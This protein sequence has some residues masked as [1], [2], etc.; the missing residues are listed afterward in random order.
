MAKVIV[1]TSGKGGVGKT[2]VTANLGY[3][4]AEKGYRVVIIDTDFGL[5]NLDVVAGVED[6]IVFDLIDV[7]ENK[8]RAKQ[9]LI[10]S[11]YNKNLFVL[12]SSHTL[13]KS[14]IQGQNVK[15]AIENILPLFDYA[16]LDC[17]A[18]I[19]AGFHRAVSVADSAILV[20]TPSV[21]SVRDA[22]KVLSILK[23]YRLND[24]SLVV[25]RI[26]GDLVL[27]GKMYSADE[28]E[29]TLGI[30]TV[31]IIPENDA[32][33]NGIVD[34]INGKTAKAFKI[35]ADNVIN[36]GNKKHDYLKAYS[37][38]FGSIKKELKK[39]I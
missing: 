21:S 1:I 20:A 4:L 34:Q 24:I 18:G 12:P 11:V 32:I 6:K 27:S 31:G 16:L 7:I 39:L 26:R 37:G 10:E 19:D 29:N 25:N 28:I 3:R 13:T 9:A 35:L 33:F 30:K 8:C 17:P 22:D 14:E 15:L 38:F 23:S 2:T 36:N 5:N